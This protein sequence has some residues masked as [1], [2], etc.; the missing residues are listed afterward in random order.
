MTREGYRV[1]LLLSL[2]LPFWKCNQIDCPKE[3]ESRNTSQKSFSDGVSNLL[4]A[5]GAGF[6]IWPWLSSLTHSY[7]YED[8]LENSHRKTSAIEKSPVMYYRL[9]ASGR[10]R[11]SATRRIAICQYISGY[12]LLR[13]TLLILWSSFRVW[14]SERSPVNWR[15]SEIL[16]GEN[17]FATLTDHVFTISKDLNID[18]CLFSMM[19]WMNMT[20]FN[21]YIAKEACSLLSKAK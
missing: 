3:P 21:E 2:E 8:W 11:G 15:E 9:I 12:T 1:V 4:N 20:W 10:I 14:L 6:P 19:H 18:A 7:K 16:R 5:A 17:V 13:M